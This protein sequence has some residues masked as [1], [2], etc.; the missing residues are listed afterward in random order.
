ME[1]EDLRPA[2]RPVVLGLGNPGESYRFTRHNLGFRALDRLAARSGACLTAT[3]ELRPTAWWAET[4]IRGERVVLAKPR[5]Y[6]NRSGRAAAELCRVFGVVPRDLVV[7][8]DDADLALGRLRLR[9]SGATG[10]HNGLRSLIDAL[11]SADFV[12]VRL[13]VRGVDRDDADLAEYVLR[14]F[15]A[16]EE[17][18]AEALADAGADAVEHLVVFGLEDTMNR[19]NGR[20][21]TSGADPDPRS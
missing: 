21:V 9:R 8:H 20:H 6:M 1:A 4:R 3:G 2:A 13:G 15:E 5:T 18:V 7:V 17:G 14:P 10:G 12:R 11:G 16:G 19:F